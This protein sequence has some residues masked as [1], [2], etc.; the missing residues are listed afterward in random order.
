M[1]IV[2][3]FLFNDELDMLFYRLSVLHEVVDT[4]VLVESQ[5]TFSG[6]AKSLVFEE[7]QS[8]FAPWKSK[9]VHVVLGTSPFR[10]P[11]IRFDRKD[12]WKNEEFQRNGMQRGFNSL[13]LSEEDLLLINDVDEIPDPQTLM[14]IR[15][16]EIRILQACSL[17]QDFYYYHLQSQVQM[18]WTLAK[19]V[20][21]GFYRAQGWT[22]H[23]YR[24]KTFPVLPRAGWHL[25]YFGDK[26]FIQ[27]KIQHFSHQE[28][29]QE[30]YTDL[31]K[32]QSRMDGHM[33]LFGR[34]EQVIQHVSLQDNQYLPPRDW[35]LLLAFLET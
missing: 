19:L 35:E 26:A 1:K 11:H 30:D 9:I 33:D 15:A 20:N 18:K 10:Q 2:D 29:N 12:Q 4:F 23:E 7:N 34:P 28:Y 27:R 13:C 31:D 3:C 6:E 22:C 32:I 8:R 24:W 5:F 14:R 16:Q 25:S 21:V 17:E